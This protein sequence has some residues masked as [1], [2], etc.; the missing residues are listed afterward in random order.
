SDGKGSVL[1]IGRTAD[2]TIDGR[3][4]AAAVSAVAAVLLLLAP[5]ASAVGS[6]GPATAF[7]PQELLDA[8]AA[9]PA[10]LFRVIV[11]G[12]PS[13]P[14]TTVGAGVEQPMTGAPAP[15]AWVNGAFASIGAVAAELTGEQIQLLAADPGVFAI[16]PDM[17]VRASVADPPTPLEPPVVT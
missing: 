13:Q 8:T 3:H 10:Q 5:G 4:L 1:R 16:P 9:S 12:T 11:Q 15:G 2:A 6:G 7:V 14:V 17:P